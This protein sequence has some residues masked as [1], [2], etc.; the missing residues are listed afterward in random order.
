MNSELLVNC[1]DISLQINLPRSVI[2]NQCNSNEKCYYVN[3][4]CY[5]KMQITPLPA[6]GALLNNFACNISETPSR[7]G[8]LLQCPNVDRGTYIFDNISYNRDCLK[9]DSSC[10]LIKTINPNASDKEAIVQYVNGN[11]PQPLFISRENANNMTNN[12]KNT[13]GKLYFGDIYGNTN[14]EIPFNIVPSINDISSTNYK[15][16]NPDSNLLSNIQNMN[17]TIRQNLEL[18]INI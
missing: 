17:E 13:N 3:N 12:F 2:K 10:N 4:A 16:L 18:L 5:D 9:S 8:Y 7:N 14:V 15:L 11:L 6:N 1:N